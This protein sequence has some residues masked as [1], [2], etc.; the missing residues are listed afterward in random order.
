M[1]AGVYAGL[2]G[3]EWLAVGP[4]FLKGAVEA[5]CFAVLP[6]VAGFDQDVLR[7]QLGQGV[8]E[9]RHFQSP[10]SSL[11][12]DRGLVPH[13]WIAGRNSGYGVQ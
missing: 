10:V 2:V 12:V 5:F 3:S 6:R 13:I 1:A 9:V 11:P 7:A 4:A 8:L